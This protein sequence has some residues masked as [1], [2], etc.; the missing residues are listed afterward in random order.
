[1]SR[2]KNGAANPRARTASKQVLFFGE[3][4]HDAKA[5]KLLFLGLRESQSNVKAKVLRQPISLVKGLDSA[6]QRR[7]VEMVTATVR[8]LNTQ[9]P[10][11]ATVFHED[12]DKC[13]PAHIPIEKEILAL[14]SGLPGTVIAAI[15]AWELESWWFLFPTA[16]GSVRSS[17]RDPD[18]HVGKEVGKI[19]NAKEALKLCVRPNGVRR[20]PRFPEYEEADSERIAEKIV[21]M[22]LVR[23]PAGKSDSW[24]S[25]VKQVDDLQ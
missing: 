22:G 10:V 8:A 6:K 7:R 18:Q 20:G 2:N 23:Q 17:W 14:Y 12:A 15:P 19:T 1:M 24:T 21:S 13:E 11:L 9:L 25:F 4:D 3:D 16:T 5:I